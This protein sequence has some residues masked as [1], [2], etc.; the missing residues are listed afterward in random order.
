MSR[1]EPEGEVLL[2]PQTEMLLQEQP[3]FTQGCIA[4]A[5]LGSEVISGGRGKRWA[6]AGGV[7]VRG[8]PAALLCPGM[9]LGQGCGLARHGAAPPDSAARHAWHSASVSSL[10]VCF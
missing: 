4:G 7:Q 1:A 10:V 8:L 5:A 6:A 9:A 2:R 3:P